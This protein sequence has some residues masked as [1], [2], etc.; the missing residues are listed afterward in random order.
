MRH[1]EWIKRCTEVLAQKAEYPSDVLLGVYIKEYTLCETDRS[2]V[3]EHFQGAD[4]SMAWKELSESLALQQRHTEGLLRRSN[5]WD[6][7]ELSY[8]ILLFY[9]LTFPRGCA[10]RAQCNINASS[11][12]A[13]IHFPRQCT[14]TPSTMLISTRYYQQL[15]RNAV[16]SAC[17]PARFIIQYT[18]VQLS[19]SLQALPTISCAAQDIWYQKTR[20][21]H[22]R[23]CCDEENG[24]AFSR[25]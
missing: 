5:L 24:R 12:T 19:A 4:K 18:L 7:C 2:L 20:H 11:W 25:R 6:N 3:G 14:A 23:T 17:S 10:H 22:P 9:I 16:T 1:T 13:K 8:D 15:P 21:T